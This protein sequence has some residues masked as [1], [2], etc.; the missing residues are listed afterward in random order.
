MFPSFK[1]QDFAFLVWLFKNIIAGNK[2]QRMARFYRTSCTWHASAVCCCR[3]LLW[4]G[5]WSCSYWWGCCCCCCWCCCSWWRAGRRL[6]WYWKKNS[7]VNSQQKLLHERGTTNSHKMPSP[8]SLCRF[9]YWKTRSILLRKLKFEYRHNIIQIYRQ[10]DRHTDRQPIKN[11]EQTNILKF[12]IRNLFI[13]KLKN[14]TWI[15]Y[16]PPPP[17]LELHLP[18]MVKMPKICG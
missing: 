8:E 4:W 14:I 13:L 10:T 17:H 12:D 5:C 11:K 15:N 1:S 16:Y 2:K 9:V 3:R 18:R 6:S 7:M